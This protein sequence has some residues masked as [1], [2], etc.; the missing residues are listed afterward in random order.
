MRSVNCSGLDSV[1]LGLATPDPS[2][3]VKTSFTVWKPFNFYHYKGM[4]K[5]KTIPKILYAVTLLSFHCLFQI[6]KN[7]I[8]IDLFD[9]RVGWI[10]ILSPCLVSN[11]YDY[12]F[13]PFGLFYMKYTLI[14]LAWSGC[15][16]IS[17]P[18]PQWSSPP[19]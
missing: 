6:Q 2:T 4:Q 11:Q 8:S 15:P 16:N 7:L 12:I 14:C 17:L 19:H 3:K 5:S 18:N 13:G 1:R 10:L 9:W